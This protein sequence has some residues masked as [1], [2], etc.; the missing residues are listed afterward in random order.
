MSLGV[1]NLSR[2][3]LVSGAR[4]AQLVAL[5]NAFAAWESKPSV[6]SYS[7]NLMFGNPVADPFSASASELNS[8]MADAR[9]FIEPDHS[10]DTGARD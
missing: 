6:W 2:A 4:Q 1:T 3:T 7:D 5:A 10:W 8:R 9:G